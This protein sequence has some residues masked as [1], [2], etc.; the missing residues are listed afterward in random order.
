M[1]IT[2]GGFTLDKNDAKM[3]SSVFEYIEPRNGTL[4]IQIAD[5]ATPNLPVDAN[6]RISFMDKSETPQVLKYIN[7]YRAETVEDVQEQIETLAASME[8][9]SGGNA[10]GMTLEI[11]N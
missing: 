8:E 7:L 5:G 9:V 6:R 1:D 10:H 4:N 2:T 3:M 11:S